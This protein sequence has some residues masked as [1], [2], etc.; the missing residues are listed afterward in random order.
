MTQI[1]PKESNPHTIFIGDSIMFKNFTKLTVSLAL[2]GAM[3]VPAFAG[4]PNFGG[5]NGGQSRSN[6]KS[7]SGNIMSS[8]K[9][10]VAQR[11]TNTN[12]NLNINKN[13][14]KFN[15]IGNNFNTGIKKSDLG[16][17]NSIGLN[18]NTGIAGQ[19]KNQKIQPRNPA[20]TGNVIKN[21]GIKMSDLVKTGKN[22]G[23][24][25]NGIVNKIGQVNGI[26]NSMKKIDPGFSKG[27]F[28]FHNNHCHSNF[29]WDSYCNHHHCHTCWDPCYTCYTPICTP[30][31]YVV[32]YP[33]YVPVTVAVPVEQQVIVNASTQQVVPASVQQPMADGA[34]AEQIA[35]PPAAGGADLSVEDIK[36][37]DVGDP[38]KSL[39]P[40]FRVTM[41]NNGAAPAVKF[42]LGLFASLNDKPGDKMVSGGVEIEG[43]AGG[44]VKEFD[45]RMPIEALS[46]KADEKAA[47]E[48]FK[49]IFAVADPANTVT[50]TE[51]KNNI[52]GMARDS[53]QKLDVAAAQ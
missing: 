30:C 10:Q 50:E 43:L 8:N 24:G 52:K 4:K 27:N 22:Q 14:A 16:I 46:I 3:A 37:L 2:L 19:I 13:I 48:V 38:A 31:Q 23:I 39:G 12:S 25:L 49:F 17:K 41:K 40:M 9:F 15:P 33:V 36:V 7:N 34:P 21:S 6:F 53:I 32:E 44:E 5:G 42:G 45:V 11:Q 18:G 47:G 26:H 28:H 29:W 1:K 20:N 51:K 35:T